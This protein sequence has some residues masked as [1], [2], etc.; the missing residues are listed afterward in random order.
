MNRKLVDMLESR[1]QIYP[2]VLTNAHGKKL[3]PDYLRLSFERSVL[4]AGLNPKFHFHHLR[5]TF[6]TMLIHKGVPI[7]EV[8]HLLGHRSVNTTQIYAHVGA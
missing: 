8:Q 4:K 5:H 2:Y 7:Y 3:Y 1:S 6:A